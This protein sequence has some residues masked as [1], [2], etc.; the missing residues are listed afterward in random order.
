M[1]IKGQLS[2]SLKKN[3][4]DTVLPYQLKALVPFE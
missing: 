2:L 1:K 3:M 4:V